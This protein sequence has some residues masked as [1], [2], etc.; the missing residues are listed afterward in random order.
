MAASENIVFKSLIAL[1]IEN[2]LTLNNS[3]LLFRAHWFEICFKLI[4][5]FF[6]LTQLISLCFS[7]CLACVI[8]VN[9][10]VGLV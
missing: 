9:F 10:L 5:V 2:Y 3:K 8:V 4:F 6:N 7:F 1:L